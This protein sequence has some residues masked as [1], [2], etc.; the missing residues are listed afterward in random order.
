MMIATVGL[1]ATHIPLPKS[2]GFWIAQWTPSA[3]VITASMP[4]ATNWPKASHQA[5]VRQ[6]APL[7]MGVLRSVQFFP[8]G[9]VI[10]SCPVCGV[11]L[12]MAANRRSEGD[13]ATSFHWPL[14]VVCGCQSGGS[15]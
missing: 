13:Q 9:E 10:T 7:T 3:E 2:G 12:E 8:S 11:A 14:G 15:G 5:I 4:T 1:P 6:K